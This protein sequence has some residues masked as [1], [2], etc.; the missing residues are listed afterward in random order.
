MVVRLK[1]ITREMLKIYKPYSNLDWM[2]Y[3]L[4][5]K[6]LTA[7]HIKKRENGG[8]L[9]KENIALLNST[10]H[11]YLHLIE[12]KDFDAYV[13]INKIFKFVNL[14]THEPTKEQRE[15]IEYLLSEFEKSHEEE[16]NAKGKILIKEEYKRRVVL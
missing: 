12:F 15:I 10:S 16:K 13:T 11:N 6:D 5:K 1:N 4:V 14:Q 8:R 2:N 7:H 9:V 3:R